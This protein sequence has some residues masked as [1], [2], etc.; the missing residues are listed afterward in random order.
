M[1][2]PNDDHEQME[3]EQFEY[4]DALISIMDMGFTNSAKIKKLL[5]K[6]KG[7]KQTVIQEL[8]STKNQ[9]Y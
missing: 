5:N 2:G 7:N 8:V 3:Q 1:D 4:E 6:H 9:I